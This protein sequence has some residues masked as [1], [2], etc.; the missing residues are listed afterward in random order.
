M[1]YEGL[2]M[3]GRVAAKCKAIAQLTPWPSTCND[4]TTLPSMTNSPSSD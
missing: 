1:N 2:G 4:Y 3:V